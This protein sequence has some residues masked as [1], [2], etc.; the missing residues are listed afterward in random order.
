MTIVFKPTSKEFQLLEPLLGEQVSLSVTEIGL[1]NKALAVKVD[2][3]HSNEKFDSCMSNFEGD[4]NAKENNLSKNKI[5]HITVG[6]FTKNKGK[7]FHSNLIKQWEKIDSFVLSG[8]I[9]A[10]Y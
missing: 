8:N 1:S 4:K 5:P 2:T 10:F 6:I 7:A 9:K 3:L